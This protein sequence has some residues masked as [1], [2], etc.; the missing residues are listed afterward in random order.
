MNFTTMIN[1]LLLNLLDMKNIFLSK[2]S[3]ILLLFCANISAQIVRSDYRRGHEISTGKWE[4][5]DITFKTRRAF[6]ENPFDVVFGAHVYDSE[7]GLKNI[8][9]FFNGNGEWVIRF[10]SNKPGIFSFTTYSSHS[11]ISGLSGKI[12]VSPDHRQGKPG[13]VIIDPESPR[14]FSYEDGSPYF[15]IIY[16]LDWLFALDAENLKDI[17]RTKQIIHDIKQNGFNQVIM[18]VYAY[19]CTWKK[20]PEIPEIYDYASPSVFPWKGTNQEPDFSELN[21]DFF[22]HLDRVIHHLDQE[23]IVARLMIY[24]WNKHVNWPGMYS[25]ADNTYFDYII[26]RYQ[27]FPNMI[28]DV[29]KEALDYGRCDIEYVNE[30]IKRIR[31]LDAYGRLLTVHDYEYCSR[32]HHRIDFISI[33]SWR[34]N[35]YNLML[36][37]WQIHTD[38][39]VVNMEHGGY[40]EGPYLS[41]EG[42]YVSAEQ[43]LVRAWECVFA[44]VYPSYYWQNSA[45]DI[46]IFDALDEKHDFDRPKYEYYRHMADFFS[47]YNYNEFF[48]VEQK[49]TT[50][51]RQDLENLAT[52]GYPLTNGTDRFIFLVPAAT[53]IINTVLPEPGSGK[54]KAVWF[55]IYTGEYAGE[56]VAQWRGWNEFRSPWKNTDALLVIEYE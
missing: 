22:K 15:G 1:K 34:P 24:V 49:L 53:Y 50:N 55:N 11:E 5:V 17:P 42:N 51:N 7:Q 47:R 14:H 29:S 25:N 35:L 12:R 4:I 28:W 33:Q 38:K 20:S 16:E 30:R 19:E 54:L 32:E 43:C 23:D 9:G 31:N 27:A 18:N 40:E 52:N 46:V 37:T 13:A 45:W 26:K 3:L 36:Q 44:G 39:P 6:A 2:F 8:P 21:V 48:P 41:F 10:S 56:Q